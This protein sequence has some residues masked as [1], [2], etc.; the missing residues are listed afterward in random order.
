MSGP[1]LAALLGDV[2]VS[3]FFERHWP[4][5]VLVSHGDPRRL[6][7]LVDAPELSSLEDLTALPARQWLVQSSR[8]PNGFGNVAVSGEAAAALYAA[9]L[10]VYGVEPQLRSPR[11]LR[12]LEALERDLGLAS[13]LLRASVFLSKTGPG[14]R[15][16]FDAHEAFVVQLKGR[17]RWT[18]ASNRDVRH[19]GENYLA[20][21]PVPPSLDVQL[22]RPGQPLAAVM[23]PGAVTVV[24]EPGSVMFVPRGTWHATETLEDSWHLDLLV[25]LSTWGDHLVSLLAAYVHEKAGWRAPALDPSEL[26][27]RL[28]ALITQLEGGALGAP[29]PPTP[30]AAAPTTAGR[31]RGRARRTGAP[32]RRRR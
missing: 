3:R 21:D 18:V 6:R 20:G 11:A 27:R 1:G 24:L 26:P 31:G 4:D 5:E 12:W 9:G 22:E 23:P 7:G 29:S 2:P 30:V 16:H 13:G 28:R 15:M 8:F 25:P 17:K 19:P 10:T 32:P 14:A